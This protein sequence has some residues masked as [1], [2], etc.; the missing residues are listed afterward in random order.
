MY[1][2]IH[3]N[4]NITLVIKLMYF[5]YNSLSIKYTIENI[6]FGILLSYYF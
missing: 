1:I 3:I 6:N 2:Y 4:D 5:H